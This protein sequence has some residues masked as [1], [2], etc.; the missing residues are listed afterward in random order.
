MGDTELSLSSI[1]SKLAAG[2]DLIKYL[3]YQMRK[4]KGA[5]GKYEC[6]QGVRS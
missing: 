2:E 3:N 6:D 4:V 1:F 5:G